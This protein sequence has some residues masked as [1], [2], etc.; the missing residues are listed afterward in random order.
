MA[1]R[2]LALLLMLLPLLAQGRTVTAR[3]SD[4]WDQNCDVHSWHAAG[5]DF[6]AVEGPDATA[7]PR[8]GASTRE[9]K[10]FATSSVTVSGLRA[11]TEIS[12]EVGS[13]SQMGTVSCDQGRI[14]EQGAKTLVWHGDAT[15]VTFTVSRYADQASSEANRYKPGQLFTRA[16]T[17]TTRDDALEPVEI[18]PR[19]G[20]FDNAV[21]V[22]LRCD[23]PGALISYRLP[24][25]TEGEGADSV[26]V[27]VDCSGTLYATA[28]LGDHQDS[29][30]ADFSFRCARP[31]FL[32]QP[33]TEVP[34]GGRIE[35]STPT[36]GAELRYTTD[37]EAPDQDSPTVPPQGI[38]MAWVC[39][40][41]ISVAAFKQGY[42]PSQVETATFYPP[43]GRPS[44]IDTTIDFTALGLA[45]NEELA[46]ASDR[47]GTVTLELMQG[48]HATLAPR[49]Y[50][51]TPS[52]RLFRGNVMRVTC[53]AGRIL[54]VVIRGTATSYRFTGSADPEGYLVSQGAVATYRSYATDG[55]GQ[56]EFTQ[57][58]YAAEAARMQSVTVTYLPGSGVGETTAP[59]PGGEAAYYDLLGR[60]LREQCRGVCV[61]VSAG[62]AV[63]VM[64][65]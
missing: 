3:W 35:V 31:R 30:D 42:A 57:S 4:I 61:R 63:K 41:E 26:R 27:E 45:D 51:K 53:H 19:G 17:V 15:S 39:P 49:F 54:E 16:V 29:A 10:L 7:P 18:W 13:R 23:T 44:R 22:L 14:V 25:G 28:T 48:Q 50:A 47:Y 52:M 2:A 24:D 34:D 46:Q 36:A 32:T 43:G 37:G 64:R 20:E 56:V 62:R 60:R 38:A 12:W 11:M 58:P 1:P 59:A 5:L 33:L 6:T 8:Y 65:P 40:V 21:G 9:L 55:V